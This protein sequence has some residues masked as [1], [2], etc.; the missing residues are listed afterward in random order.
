MAKEPPK[1][2][3]ESYK[4]VRDFYPEEMF[5]QNY[6]FGKMRQS[7]ESFGYV[8]YSASIL[9]PAELYRAKSGEEI[10]N[11][12]TY[13]FRDRG[14]REVTLRP[15]MTPSVARLVAKKKRTLTF[16]LRWYSIPN[17]F[18]YERPQKGRLREH[19]QL[20]ADIFGIPDT[21]ADIEIISLAGDIMKNFGAKEKDFVIKINHRK[22]MEA[23]ISD[24]LKIGDKSAKRVAKLID[25]KE[26]ISQ[27]EFDEEAKILSGERFGLF[28]ALLKSKNL[29]EF[30]SLLPESIAKGQPAKEM[31]KI[32]G[33]LERA[34]TGNVVF[35]Q[36]LM[37]G[38]DYYTGVIFEVFSSDP[39]DKRSLFG[40]GRY[41]DLLDIFGAERVP[42]V[43]FGM[44]DVTMSD[45]L[46]KNS[47][48]PEYRSPTDLYI[49]ALGEEYLTLSF[50][51]AASLRESGLNVLVNAGS[52][53][54]DHIKK[55][56]KLSI[57]YIAFIGETEEKRKEFMVKELESGREHLCFED[58][59]SQVG[60]IIKR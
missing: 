57:P 23:V 39:E 27:K 12:Q 11:E 54:Q 30:L 22:L 53:P 34:G 33:S 35:D 58:A 55:A 60:T 16:P 15:E 46:E 36:S 10:A 40:G 2:E 41:D 18:R 14:D 19:W 50:S 3:T 31:M 25:K 48:K 43:G 28:S 24:T 8:E 42:A 59:L 44:G 1:L 45:F 6:I 13:I 4:G 47:L 52:K 51:I 9:E 7:A 5:L 21:W 56:E 17:V 26:K 49:G 32:M 38:F 20:N 37:R 29:S